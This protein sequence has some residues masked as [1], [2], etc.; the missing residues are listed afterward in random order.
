MKALVKGLYFEHFYKSLLLRTYINSKLIF[1][2][3]T[4]LFKNFSVEALSVFT[5]KQHKKHLLNYFCRK[6]VTQINSENNILI[7]VLILKEFCKGNIS[8]GTPLVVNATK[9]DLNINIATKVNIKGRG[10]KQNKKSKPFK[11]IESDESDIHLTNLSLRSR[12]SLYQTRFRIR[13]KLKSLLHK[14]FH[15]NDYIEVDTP[16]LS[17]YLRNF[18]QKTFYVEPTVYENGVDPVNSFFGDP[19]YL[20]TC[21]QIHMEC[22]TSA[23]SK[24][25]SIKPIFRRAEKTGKTLYEFWKA[26][27]EE[28]YT[29]ERRRDAFENMLRNLEKLLKHLMKS[30]L[31]SHLSEMELSKEGE[32]VVTNALDKKWIIL[33]YSE[34][35]A[36]LLDNNEKVTYPVEYGMDFGVQCYKL[37]PKN[38]DGSPVFITDYPYY[39]KGFNVSACEDS[40]NVFAFDLIFPR[41]IEVANGSIKE[42]DF[43]IL[44][45]NLKEYGALEYYDWFANMRKWGVG[46]TRGYSIG[47]ERFLYFMFND[48]N[49]K[50]VI[51][52]PRYNRS[53]VC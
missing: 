28:L 34:A 2:Q 32:K 15:E 25:Y 3:Q 13:S 31:D 51:P 29:E 8:I 20:S 22:I 44:E 42:H 24:V 47:I 7:Q 40:I 43:N 52:F 46:P 35:M 9:S 39:R 30:I 48:S 41:G 33:P 6:I 16:I 18:H 45:Q 12:F 49:V 10:Y 53:C 26:D 23:L 4:I 21:G 17:R 19:V 36:I 14:Y 27:C 37:F 1:K 50:N 38:F 11:N 5:D